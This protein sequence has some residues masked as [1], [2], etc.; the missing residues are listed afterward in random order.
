M[1]GCLRR[2]NV[3]VHMCACTSDF[4]ISQIPGSK[5]TLFYYYVMVFLELLKK[6]KSMFGFFFQ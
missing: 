4:T 3:T 2:L 1:G 6:K 5:K